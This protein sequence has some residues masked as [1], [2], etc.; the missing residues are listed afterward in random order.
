MQLTEKHIIKRNSP[1]Y[2]ECERICLASK[3]IYNRALYLIRQD[4]EKNQSYNALNNIYKIMQDEECYKQL[5][6]KVSQQTLR[7]VKATMAS[8][9]GHLKV[10][11][12]GEK[13]NTP[14]FLHKTKGRYV[15][16]F[17]IQSVSKKIFDKN[18]KVKLSGCDLEVHTL[19]TKYDSI[20]CVRVVPQNNGERYV[21]EIVYTVED[22]PRLPNNRTYAAID[23]GVSNLATMVSNK[24]GFQP[25]II[26]GKPLKSIN[27]YYN[28]RKAQLQSKLEGRAKSSK[29]IRRLTLKRNDKVND[30]M[31]KASRQIVDTLS[32]NDIRCLII[33]KND[34]WKQEVN[35]GSANNQNFVSIPHSRFIGMLTYK[36]ERRGIEVR[37]QEESYSS[38]C[39]FLDMEEVGKHEEYV[40]KRVKRG[41]FK[42]S[43]GRFINA[44]VNGAYNIMRK[45]V[46]STVRRG[47]EGF[48]VTPRTIAVRN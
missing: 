3:N 11:K 47:I 10:R 12:Q 44:D 9:F 41:L 18:H 4:Y 19:I 40:G 23:L 17:S 21:F 30:Y 28:K 42:S 33:G 46:P 43:D 14:H 24:D 38:K 36:C 45:A 5:P 29:R 32:E 2:G 15:T 39:S 6:A 26:N 22:T 20:D 16:R 25:L 13:I 37:L 31:H 35:V 8:F 1:L 7:M 34:G 48:V 27:Q